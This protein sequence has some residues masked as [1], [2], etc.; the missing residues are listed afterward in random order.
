[1]YMPN[2]KDFLVV[3]DF[4]GVIWDTVDECFHVGYRT[5]GKIKKKIP[6]NPEQIKRAFRSGRFLAR[7]GDDFFII[8]HLINE[9]P[10]I[11]FENLPFEEFIAHRKKLKD[12]ISL[13]SREFYTE[14]S[15]LQK[16]NS[17]VWLQMQGPFP[18]VLEQ[19][20]DIKEN[21][22]NLVICSA[23][24]RASIDI[25]LKLH[26]QKHEVYGREIST[27]KPDQ[28]I[29]LSRKE[30][31]PTERMIFLD[32]LLENLQHVQ[33]LG[34]KTAMADWGYSNERQRQAALNAGIP[35]ISRHNLKDA[36]SKLCY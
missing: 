5:F 20:P 7:T 23:K 36:L 29:N 15:R 14:R 27:H 10:E 18:G 13:F 4:D 22:Q 30:N 12:E 11:D 21:F 3:F 28:I 1:M 16:E 32:D 31:I 2:C 19:L 33:V 17:D 35:I 9:N 26:D 24:D 8:L 34:V 25:L 6:G